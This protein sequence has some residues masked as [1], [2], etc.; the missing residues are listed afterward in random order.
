MTLVTFNTVQVHFLPEVT[1]QLAS[2]QTALKGLHLL[3][4]SFKLSSNSLPSIQGIA[5]IPS[6]PRNDGFEKNLTNI[7]DP[8]D[9]NNS[10][11]Q[12]I[13]QNAVPRKFDHIMI[14]WFILFLVTYLNTKR[15]SFLCSR[16]L[17][18]SVTSMVQLLCFQ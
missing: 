4:R 17:V 10:E 16:N 6:L 15:Q 3:Q 9:K 8:E 13:V 14:I 18:L 12:R 2:L 11:T 7:K 1:A 5:K